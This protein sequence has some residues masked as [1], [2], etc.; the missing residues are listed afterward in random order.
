MGVVASVEGGQQTSRVVGV[1][2]TNVQSGLFCEG[3]GRV[4]H[5]VAVEGVNQDGEFH[6]RADRTELHQPVHPCC[7]RLAVLHLPEKG[8]DERAVLR[9]VQVGACHQSAHGLLRDVGKDCLQGPDQ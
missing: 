5:A 9:I 8:Q 2:E 6:G 3:I 1:V 7:F 4:G